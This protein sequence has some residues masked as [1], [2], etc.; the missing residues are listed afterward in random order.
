ME[1]GARDAKEFMLKTSTL[2]TKTVRIMSKH[3]EDK[4][5]KMTITVVRGEETISFQT[6]PDLHI[7]EFR[8]LMMRLAAAV[9]YQQTNI[10]EYF[11]PKEE[12]DTQ[13]ANEATVQNFQQDM[14]TVHNDILAKNLTLPSP[15]ITND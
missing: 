1:Q 8:D 13:F 9:G 14:D 11:L 7:S 10:E 15:T 6:D 4:D 5:D 2:G 3:T 12:Q